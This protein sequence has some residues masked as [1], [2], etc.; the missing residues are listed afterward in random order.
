MPKKKVVKKV[1]AKETATN[2]ADVAAKV[3]E[4]EA[5]IE[6]DRKLREKNGVVETPEETRARE[7]QEQ[8]KLSEA[9]GQPLAVSEQDAKIAAVEAEIEADRKLRE[10]NSVV[11]TPEQTRARELDEN[12]KLADA[13]GEV[14]ADERTH[15]ENRA[16]RVAGVKT[17]IEQARVERE[18]QEKNGVMETPGAKLDREAKEAKDLEEASRLNV[19]EPFA[20]ATT[21][22]LDLTSIEKKVNEVISY[23]NDMSWNRYDVTIDDE[24]EVVEE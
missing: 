23:I 1:A 20:I 6:A 12:F 7:L 18:L 24:D 11:E 19:I 4:V 13:K 8:N 14:T 21:N 22:N 10:E 5:Q 2:E 3:S 16:T 15:W 9:K 17:A